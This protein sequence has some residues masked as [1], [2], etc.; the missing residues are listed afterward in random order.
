[1]ADLGMIIELDPSSC[2]SSVT[3][4]SNDELKASFSPRLDSNDGFEVKNEPE[5]H[6]P[7][8]NKYRYFVI[9]VN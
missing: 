7:H 1:M 3:G 6:S 4:S 2:N 9:A 8:R 5:R